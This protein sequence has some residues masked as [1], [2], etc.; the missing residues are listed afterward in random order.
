MPKIAFITGI[1]GQDAAYLSQ[2]L[3]QKGY[4]VIGLNHALTDGKLWRLQELGID[5]EINLIDG[6]IL[7]TTLMFDLIKKYQPAELYNLAAISFVGLSWKMAGLTFDTNA[8]AVVD[9]LEAIKQNSPQTRLYQPGSSEMFGQPKNSERQNEL[10]EFNPCNPYGV[11][12]AAA[13]R[14]VKIYREAYGIFGCNA[15][16]YNHESPLR[17]I[18]YVTRKITDG[19]VRI[20]LG[21]EKE[22]RLGNIAARRDWGYAGDYVEA[23]WFMLQAE[24]PDDYVVA[25]G[26]THSLA[27]FLKAAFAAVDI[28]DWQ[29]YVK[30]DER[31]FRPL[32]PFPL[33]GDNSKIKEMLGWSPRLPFD[34]LVAM[35]AAEDLKRLSD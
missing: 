1:C 13:Y 8:R 22:I 16:C 30:E 34:D 5:K 28:L 15:I 23:M 24:K 17:G 12:K 35:M 31:F 29:K 11:A 26:A 10:T 25:T 7:D 21:L 33:C 20:K 14:A 3:L 32:E 9:I 27:D 6:D 4:Q 18:E 19:V 2:L